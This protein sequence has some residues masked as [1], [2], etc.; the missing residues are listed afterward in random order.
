MPLFAKI[1]AFTLIVNYNVFILKMLYR[2]FASLICFSFVPPFSAA[3]SMSK[4]LD[5][6]TTSLFE[7]LSTLT[8]I[9]TTLFQSG[10]SDSHFFQSSSLLGF[11]P[12]A[13]ISLFR[14]SIQ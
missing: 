2:K 10:F 14:S 12:D 5:I 6:A 7:L 11:P 8:G 13:I 9:N 4:L 3:L 1:M